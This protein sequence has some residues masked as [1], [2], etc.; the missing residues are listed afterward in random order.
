MIR[1]ERSALGT[2]GATVGALGLWGVL[3]RFKCGLGRHRRDTLMAH[4]SAFGVMRRL[5]KGCFEGWGEG[6][7]VDLGEGGVKGLWGGLERFRGDFASI[8]E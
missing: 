3:E 5:N 8:D 4:I 1:D 7:V 6:C 2:I